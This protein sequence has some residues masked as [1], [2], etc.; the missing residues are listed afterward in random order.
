[1]A[2]HTIKS[3]DTP[4]SLA[5]KYTGAGTRWKELCS[6]NPQ[7][8][9]HATYG[10]VFTVG[11]VLTLP[12][13]WVPEQN[14]EKPL[15]A[16]VP[17]VNPTVQ[18]TSPVQPLPTVDQTMPKQVVSPIPAKPAYVAP[19]P[20]T[21][22]GSFIPGLPDTIAG[23]DTNYLLMGTAGLALIGMAFL[24]TGGKPGKAAAVA[25]ATELKQNPSKRS[26]SRKSRRSQKGKRRSA[27]PR[28]RAR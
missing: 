8:P 28:K 12:D 17:A 15:Y 20:I 10:C 4:W 11:K 19:A 2:T 6:A 9:K 27:K 23:I 7:L 18:P 25:P 26:R 22:G 24:V 5:V 3:G 13:S 16:V 1:M 14:V 21:G